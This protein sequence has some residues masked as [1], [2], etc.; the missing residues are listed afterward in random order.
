[1]S[2]TTYVFMEKY[3]KYPCFS[4]KKVSLSGVMGLVLYDDAS[5]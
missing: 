1:M 5:V 2:T 4:V 3:D